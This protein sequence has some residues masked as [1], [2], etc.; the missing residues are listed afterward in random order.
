MNPR[1][2]A[3]IVESKPIMAIVV[4]GFSGSVCAVKILRRAKAE[5]TKTRVAVVERSGTIGERLAYGTRDPLHRLNVPAGRCW[6]GALD[7]QARINRQGIGR[8]RKKL[9]RLRR[10]QWRLLA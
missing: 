6:A 3:H 10:C 7:E 1:P 5:G 8:L 2:Y 9:P 4:G